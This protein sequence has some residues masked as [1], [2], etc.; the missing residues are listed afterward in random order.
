M[1]LNWIDI[2]VLTIIVSSGV[3]AFFK[4][5]IREAF[6]IIGL[7]AATI[8]SFK[9]YRPFSVYLKS[10]IAAK[11]LREFITFILLFF[12]LLAIVAFISYMAKKIFQKAGLTFY[13]KLL[14]LLFGVVRGILIAYILIIIIETTKIAPKD[15]KNSKTYY[16]VKKT[17]S[18]FVNKGTKIYKGIKK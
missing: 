9:F 16:A 4:G 15:L 3:F 18:I 12:I 8:L 6:S 13:D 17:A 14:G 11:P 10:I 2:V 5:F 1:N 7:I